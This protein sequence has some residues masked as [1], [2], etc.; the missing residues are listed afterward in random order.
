MG[1]VYRARDER[2]GRD[3]AIKVISPDLASDP[4]RLRRFQLE[5]R[6]AGKLNHPS[7]VTIYDLG[8]SGGSPYIVS[9]M[10]EGETVR[11]RLASGP[12]P[13]LKAIRAAVQFANGLSAAHAAGIVHRD[14]KPENLVITPGGSLKILDFGIAKLFQTDGAQ[15]DSTTGIAPG[16]TRTGTVLGTAS[17]MAPEQIRVQQVDHR[18][19]LFAFGA[20]LY[21][22]LTGERAFPGDT[23]A[24]RMSA[25]LGSD[26]RP[27]PRAVEQETPGIGRVVFRCLEKR[28]EDRFQDASDLAFALEL[29]EER[30][31][32]PEDPMAGAGVCGRARRVPFV[33]AAHLSGREHPDRAVH[34]GWPVRGLRG[35]AGGPAAGADV[36]PAREP[37]IEEP[38]RSGDGSLLGFLHG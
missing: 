6:A 22:M 9:E 35:G 2:L 21:E 1:V 33:R 14:L 19:D 18:T 29:V 5:A 4:E 13:V 28:P 31:P 27:L 7:I 15:E 8:S 23:V 16:M 38:G 11:E 20:I 30:E 25:I 17:Y 12:M 34:A 32:S 24:D 37:G 36:V 10:L 26:P 3:V